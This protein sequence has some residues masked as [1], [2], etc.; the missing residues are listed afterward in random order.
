MTIVETYNQFPR[1][2]FSHVEQVMS[3]KVGMIA[4]RRIS[5]RRYNGGVLIAGLQHQRHFYPSAVVV[6]DAHRRSTRRLVSLLRA[7]KTVDNNTRRTK[8]CSCGSGGGARARELLHTGNICHESSSIF[9]TLRSEW[10]T[11]RATNALIWP[12][13]PEHLNH[14][15][16]LSEQA[17]SCAPS[18]QESV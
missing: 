5:K 1:I 3:H 12:K 2:Y 10:L 14:P 15:E 11:S 6:S 8:R 13:Q 9:K 17:C 18:E 4:A 7:T 16:F